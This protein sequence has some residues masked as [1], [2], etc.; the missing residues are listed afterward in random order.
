MLSDELII[1]PDLEDVSNTIKHLYLL[2]DYFRRNN[3]ERWSDLWYANKRAGESLESIYSTDDPKF[4]QGVKEV[5][6]R[7]RD[8]AVTL[9]SQLTVINRIDFCPRVKDFIDEIRSYQGWIEEDEKVISKCEQVVSEKKSYKVN[10]WAIERMLQLHKQQL[11]I[12][13]DL[14]GDL[15]AIENSDRY[16]LENKITPKPS[17]HSTQNLFIIHGHDEARWR[18]LE[19]ILREDFGLNPIVLEE[20]PDRGAAT[21]IEK[22]EFYAPNCSYAFAIFTPDDQ[23]EKESTSYLQIRPNVIFEL[24]WFCAYLG[25]NKIMILLQEDTDLDAFSDFEGILQKRFDRNI[26]EKYKEIE[27]EL[28]LVGVIQPRK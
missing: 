6:R 16:K 14:D 22:F 13:R 9:S 21:I 12:L 11:K 20:Q 17:E 3:V 10:Y 4:I 28:I 7:G 24:G 26:R 25:R 19:K 1:R 27:T 2:A 15:H 23:V 5:Y 18:E 8:T